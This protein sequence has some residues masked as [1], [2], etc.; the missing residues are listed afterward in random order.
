MK[1]LIKNKEELLKLSTDDLAELE[2]D[3]ILTHQEIKELLYLYLL[4]KDI[5]H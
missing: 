4:N 5:S 2:R 3:G 1:E